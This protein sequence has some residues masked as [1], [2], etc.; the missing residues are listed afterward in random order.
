MIWRSGERALRIRQLAL[1]GSSGAAQQRESK[2]EGLAAGAWNAHPCIGLA[3]RDWLGVKRRTGEA[4]GVLAVSYRDE[5]QEP[6]A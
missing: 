3:P 6:A 5:R 2:C 1:E 4:A